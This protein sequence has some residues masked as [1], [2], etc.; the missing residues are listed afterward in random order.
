M[1]EK[2]TN[3]HDSSIHRSFHAGPTSGCGRLELMPRQ[4]GWKFFFFKASLCK[5]NFIKEQHQYC[6][7]LWRDLRHEAEPRWQM[8]APPHKPWILT[9]HRTKRRWKPSNTSKIKKNNNKKNAVCPICWRHR[10]S[11]AVATA[12]RVAGF[13]TFQIC[14]TNAPPL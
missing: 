1:E 11:R 5:I 6:L 13:Q 7:S 2:L 9:Q 8:T 12:I 3:K 14:R 4:D 10:S